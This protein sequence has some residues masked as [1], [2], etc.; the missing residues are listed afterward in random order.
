MLGFR[1]S[2]AGKVATITLAGL[3][4]SAAPSAAKSTQQHYRHHSQSYEQNY[5]DSRAYFGGGNEAVFPNTEDHSAECIN[6]Y[7]WIRHNH[8]WAKTTAQD[9]MPLR[10]R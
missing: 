3:M 2:T 6:G 1:L 8:D 9:T 7:R 5:T 10:C 4:L